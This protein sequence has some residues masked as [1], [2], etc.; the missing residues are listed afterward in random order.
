MISFVV[1]AYNEERLLPRTLEAIH[2]SA[3][4]LGE[5][6]EIVV[7]DDGSTDGTI[8][9]ALAGGARVVPV[10]FRQIART[11]NAGARASTGGTL[12]FVDADTVVTPPAV[13]ASVEALRRGAAGGGASV[14][15][16]GKLPF[17]ATLMIPL[18]GAVMSTA[19]LAAGCYIFC[20]RGAF[21]RAGGFDEALFAGEEIYFSRALARHGQ[22][23]I[24]RETVTTSGR[25]LRSHSGRET[26]TFVA[27]LLRHGTSVVRSRERLSLWY[28]ERRNERP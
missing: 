19:R 5:P 10:A 4:A 20:D 26:L 24:L 7:V 18:L 8:R 14:L 17:W 22:F 27:S 21:E 6:Y 28:G 13:R 9:T 2:A 15:F 23:V 12:I 3:R 25:K 1:P 16:E 11:R